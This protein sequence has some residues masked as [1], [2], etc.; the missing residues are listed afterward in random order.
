MLFRSTEAMLRS[1]DLDHSRI[2]IFS[3]YPSS[4]DITSG[5]NLSPVLFYGEGIP[6]GLLHSD[7]TRR[8]GIVG[9]I[10]IAPSI[11]QY[12]DT[13][14]PQIQGKAL[15]FVSLTDNYNFLVSL[16][17]QVVKT[18]NHRYP[19]LS[20]FASFEILILVLSLTILILREKLK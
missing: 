2:F 10:D 9:N 11:L 19:V 6:R 20:S 16:E 17:D 13:E 7:T 3:P 5:R 4:K 12:F 1:I 8:S 15:D 14:N 18:S